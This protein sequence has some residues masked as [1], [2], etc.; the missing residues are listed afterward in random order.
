MLK[1]AK[2]FRNDIMKLKLPKRPVNTQNR[3]KVEKRT[4]LRAGS[5]NGGD[6]SA[7]KKTVGCV[8]GFQLSVLLVYQLTSITETY[9]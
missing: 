5:F 1:K 2:S 7:E 4:L 8:H 9:S 6:E 3:E